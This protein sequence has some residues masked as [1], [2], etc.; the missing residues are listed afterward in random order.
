M[1]FD[2]VICDSVTSVGEGLSPAS[3]PPSSG[4]SSSCHQPPMVSMATWIVRACQVSENI[5]FPRARESCC[6]LRYD[7]STLTMIQARMM[8]LKLYSTELVGNSSTSIPTKEA[9]KHL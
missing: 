3:S 2:H 7:C 4:T 5:A 8:Q 9:L 6:K 1:D